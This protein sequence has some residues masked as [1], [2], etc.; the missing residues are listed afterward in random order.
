VTRDNQ[1]LPLPNFFL[2][3]ATIFDLDFA[4][5]FW[6]TDGGR[7]REKEKTSF[8]PFTRHH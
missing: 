8:A 5:D 7:A 2:A 3:M 4:L 1:R 6:F